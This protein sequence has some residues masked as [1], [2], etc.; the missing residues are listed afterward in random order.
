MHS[1]GFP[2]G[3]LGVFG[4]GHTK[5]LSPLTYPLVI[6]IFP[7]PAGRPYEATTPAALYMQRVENS[8]FYG[9]TN[10]QAKEAVIAGNVHVLALPPKALPKIVNDYGNDGW[11]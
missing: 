3:E 6:K 8:F 9:W 2:T 7:P 4:E 10:E 11:C 1:G 5:N